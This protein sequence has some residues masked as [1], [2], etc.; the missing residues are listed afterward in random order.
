[1]TASLALA[2]AV[3]AHRAAAED[4][5]PNEDPAVVKLRERFREGIERYRAGQYG[6]AILVWNPVYKEL[7]PAKGYRLAFNLARAFDQIHDEPRAADH[8]EA[9]LEE[10]EARVSTGE[11]LEPI[12]LKQRDEANER[13]GELRAK[14]GRLRF[15]GEPVLVAIDAGDVRV[16]RGVSYLAPGK[17]AVVWRPATPEQVRTE[18]D[19]PP[20]DVL[21]LEVPPLPSKPPVV[22]PPPVRWETRQEHP[23]PRS[24]LYAGVGLTALS[25]VV[26]PL[27]YS[28][29]LGTKDTYDRAP[30][31][32][33]RDDYASQRTAAYASWALPA[34]LGTATIALAVYWYYGEKTVRTP[35]AKTA[36]CLAF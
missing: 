25:F 23:F 1:M 7:G 18:I 26:P 22:A 13:M 36:G 32:D 29:A 4:V 12:V 19:L 10:V 6:E 28:S 30:T 20:G 16:G 33:L 21:E 5:T 27:L 11:T 17:H 3:T 8:F 34:L 15:R 31:S 9:Y 14:L 35:M 2:L 24:I